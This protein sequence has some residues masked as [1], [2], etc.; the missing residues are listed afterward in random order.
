MAQQLRTQGEKVDLLVLLD[1]Y[2][3]T[4]R[5]HAIHRVIDF[6]CRTIGLDDEAQLD[7]YLRLCAYDARWQ[8]FRQGGLGQLATLPARMRRPRLSPLVR[9]A[10][11]GRGRARAEAAETLAAANRDLNGIYRWIH[12]AYRP[13]WYPGHVVVFWAAE[14]RARHGLGPL[15]EWRKE[16]ARVHDEVIPGAHLTF[17]TTHG[18]ALAERV[19]H[20]LHRAQ[21]GERR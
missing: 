15:R 9:W 19:A 16:A 18:Q 4:R 2:L 6:V 14:E 3:P 17:L 11:A 7:C 21:A 10:Q 8:A 13:R 12:M 1:A 20:Y 5:Q